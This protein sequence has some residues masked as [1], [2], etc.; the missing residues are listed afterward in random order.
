MTSITIDEFLSKLENV[1]KSGDGYTARCSAHEDKRSSLSIREDN[2][3]ILVHCHA[4]CTFTEIVES[5]ALDPQSL[6]PQAIEKPKSKLVAKY[7]YEDISGKLIYQACRYE[8]KKFIQRR[9]DPDHPK[10]WVYNL[11]DVQ[12]LPFHLP[13]VIDAVRAGKTIF[14]VE[15]EKDVL[16]LEKLG[17]TATCNSGGAGKWRKHFSQYFS[18]ARIAMIADNDAP[19]RAHVEKVAEFLS[20]VTSAIFVVNLDGLPEHGDISNWIES[21]GTRDHLVEI[22]QTSPLWQ[23]QKEEPIPQ[24]ADDKIPADPKYAPFR[25]LGFNDGYFYYM[26]DESLQLCRMTADQHTMACLI[27]L[28]PL[29]WWEDTFPNKTSCDW[30]AAKNFLFRRSTSKGIYD[31]KKLRGCG[32]WFD[33]GRVVQ[34]NG[35]I[36]IV[37]GEAIN[38]EDFKTNYIYNASY[39]I[40]SSQAEPLSNEDAA[41]FLATC[42]MPSWEKPISGTLLAGWC[43]VA[44]ICGSLYWRPHVWLTGASGTGKTWITDNIIKTAL[45][46]TSMRAQSNTTEAGIR[47]WLGI[48]AFPVLLDETEGE[49]HRSRDRLQ[50]VIELMRQASS[51]TGA[52]IVK[53]SAHGN[54][55]EFKIRSCFCLASVNVNIHQKAD[56]SRITILSLIRPHKKD[57]VDLFDRL[58]DQ[59]KIINQNYCAGLRAR[60]IKLIP[61]ILANAR[62]FGRAIAERF[63]DQRIGDQFGVLIAGAYSLTSNKVISPED[64]C[65]WIEKQDWTEQS[66][67]EDVSDEERCLNRILEYIVMYQAEH[68]RVEKTVSEIIDTEAPSAASTQALERYGIKINDTDNGRELIISDSH[69]GVQRILHNSEHEK[70]WG[71][72]L[73]RFKGA[74]SKTSV[75]FNGKP[76]RATAI[77]IVNIFNA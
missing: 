30:N 67:I 5:L 68:S 17:L 73:K 9:P 71:R 22:A 77:P 42:K 41:K 76:Q 20:K 61:V 35:N 74:Y 72:I 15:G 7:D 55:V 63:G 53:G 2:G 51:E 64:A 19:G 49:D 38:I 60:S 8:P 57:V 37:D 24:N 3:K 50:S 1:K 18:S 12:T 75:R 44:P 52:P 26:P 48:N 31:S 45:G 62:V 69:S 58:K 33:N 21:G 34:H 16:N 43:V 46:S 59:I 6:F 36:L 13:Q 65:E 14:I 32:T 70:N 28:A 29:Q 23:P 54:A 56:A 11:K 40:E 66:S 10:K 4:G 25:I 47:Q 27:A 39:P